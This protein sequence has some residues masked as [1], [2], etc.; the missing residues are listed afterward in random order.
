MVARLLLFEVNDSLSAFQR[1][2]ITLVDGRIVA[3][4]LR[5]VASD[6]KN[7]AGNLLVSVA[8]QVEVG[9]GLDL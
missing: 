2:D 9:K 6:Q 5:C 1:T 3:E 8:G 7:I 4:S